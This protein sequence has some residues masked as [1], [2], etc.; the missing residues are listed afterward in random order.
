MFD[1]VDRNKHG[2]LMMVFDA[3]NVRYGRNTIKT[4]AQSTGRQA[5]LTSQCKLSARFTT[6]SGGNAAY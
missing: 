2:Q 3:L 4:G 6:V 1:P 5:R